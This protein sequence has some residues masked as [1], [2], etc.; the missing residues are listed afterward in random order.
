MTEE[1]VDVRLAAPRSGSQGMPQSM[2][3][4]ERNVL[5]MCSAASSEQRGS[6]NVHIEAFVGS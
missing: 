6:D 2:R 3:V 1:E 5:G 4:V